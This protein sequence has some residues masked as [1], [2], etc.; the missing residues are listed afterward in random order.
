LLFILA[1]LSKLSY[2]GWYNPSWLRSPL[3]LLVGCWSRV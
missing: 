1:P 3:L 2:P